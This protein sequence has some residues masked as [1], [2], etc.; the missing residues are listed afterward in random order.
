MKVAAVALSPVVGGKVLHVDDQQARAIKGVVD[1]VVLEDAVAVTAGD[2]W[3]ASK[4]VAALKIRWDHGRN[5]EISTKAF[6]A[7]MTEASRSG[8]AGSS[9]KMRSRLN[10]IGKYPAYITL[11]LP[12]V[13]A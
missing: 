11:S 12:R 13:L 9:R 7:E 10:P 3:T 8:T 5:A 4:A 1:V 2:F 6:F